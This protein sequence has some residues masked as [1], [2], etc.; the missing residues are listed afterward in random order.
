MPVFIRKIRNKKRWRVKDSKGK[1]FSKST[2]LKKAKAQLRLL[3][4]LR[5]IKS[6]K[7]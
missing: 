3:R 7:N 6:R 5:Y 2:S 1:V 4:A